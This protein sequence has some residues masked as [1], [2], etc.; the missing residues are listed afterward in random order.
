MTY[1]VVVTSEVAQAHGK[2]AGFTNPP[3][4]APRARACEA[5][6]RLTAG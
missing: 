5:A 6:A 4:S 1:G 2:S 3:P